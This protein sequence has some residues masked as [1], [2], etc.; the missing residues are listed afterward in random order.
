MI[1][2][3]HIQVYIQKNWGKISKKYLRTYV[4]KSLFHSSQEVKATQVSIKE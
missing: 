3:V 2:Q 1:Q 4:H